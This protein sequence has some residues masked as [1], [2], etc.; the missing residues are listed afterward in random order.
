MNDICEDLN[1][2]KQIDEIKWYHEFD[3]PGGLKARS[4][5]PDVADH[6]KFWTFIEKQLDSIDFRNKTV[7]DIGCWDGFWSFYAEKKG[8]KRVLATD[9]QTQ[10]WAG[11]S[12]LKLAHKLYRSSVEIRDDISVYKLQDLEEKFD[13]IMCLGVYYHLI[14]PFY[15]FAQIRHCCHDDT[16]VIFE[17]DMSH[18]LQPNS[19]HFDPSAPE[20]AAFVPSKHSLNLMLSAA[21]FEVVSQKTLR[22]EKKFNWRFKLHSFADILF[23]LID[24]IV[25][26]TDS[27][28][29]SLDRVVTVCRPFYG[30]NTLHPFEPPFQLHRYDDRFC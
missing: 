12:G 2:K 15:A 13:I 6:R 25:P 18:R 28:P 24:C 11:S 9:D 10:N 1:L 4:S 7:L 16:I 26:R 19:I 3:F 23:A 8:A 5:T 14:D 27:S 17:G 20:R 30:K 21:Y 29:I 22:T